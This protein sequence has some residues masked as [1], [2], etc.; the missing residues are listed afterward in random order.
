VLNLAAAY[1]LGRGWRAGVRAV[2]YTG[3]PA[4]VG[5]V[6]AAREPPRTPPF[7]RFDWRL[8]KRWTIGPATSWAL[9]A[10]VLNTTLHKEIARESC[11]A[12]YCKQEPIGPVT[13]PSIGVEATF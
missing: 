7:Y 13:V 8:E 6:A 2:Y 10:E 1:D 11:N 5:Y 12:Y 9:V 4:K 3:I